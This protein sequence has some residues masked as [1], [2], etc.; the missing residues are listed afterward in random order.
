MAAA[1][2]LAGCGSESDYANDPRPPTPINISASISP[3]KVTVSPQ[4]F[5][6][7]PVTFLIANLTD[8]TQQVTVETQDL[9]QKAGIKQTSSLINPQGTATLKVDVKEGDY[10]V[11]VKSASIQE[12]HIKVGAERKSSQDQLLQP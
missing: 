12:A 6:A 1:L 9:A 11:S 2:V 3:D 4:E 5:G 7:G 10:T 8:D